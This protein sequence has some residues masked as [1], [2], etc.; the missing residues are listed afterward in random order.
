M[1][2]T[3]T[4]CY[5]PGIQP[6][7]TMIKCNNK[8]IIRKLLAYEKIVATTATIATSTTTSETRISNRDDY[9]NDKNICLLAIPK[10]KN[11]TMAK[12]EDKPPKKVQPMDQTDRPAIKPMLWRQIKESHTVSNHISQAVVQ[13]RYRGTINNNIHK[14]RL[15]KFENNFQT[16]ILEA[17]TPLRSLLLI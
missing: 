1:T 8:Y 17:D 12:I 11:L 6:K 2:T 9:N 14:C 16:K 10:D 15:S 5:E 13:E 3:A 4:I 7:Q